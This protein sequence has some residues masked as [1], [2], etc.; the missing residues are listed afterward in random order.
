MKFDDVLW[1]VVIRIHVSVF[2]Y[3][4][5]SLDYIYPYKTKFFVIKYV[6]LAVMKVWTDDG[7]IMWL[8]DTVSCSWGT[9]TFAVCA[10]RY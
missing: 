6:S 7:K 10:I 9:A 4:L 5:F 1:I 2:D 8:W 3:D